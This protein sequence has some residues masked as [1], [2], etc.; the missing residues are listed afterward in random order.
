MAVSDEAVRAGAAANR[1]LRFGWWS[2]AV[3]AM[4]GLALETMHG[5]K[6]GAYLDLSNEPRRLMWTLA[7]AHGALIALIN[8][9]YG[10]TLRREAGAGGRFA[11]RALMAGGVLLPLG[12]FLGGLVYYGGDPGLGIVLVPVGALLLVGALVSIARNTGR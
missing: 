6:V 7:H 2:L 3:F 10:L 12:F 4:A 5:F 9:V 11:S 8:I 1:H